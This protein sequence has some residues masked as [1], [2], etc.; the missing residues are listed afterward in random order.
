M[1][2][3]TIDLAPIPPAISSK[4]LSLPELIT[5]LNDEH[6]QVIASASFQSSGW[7]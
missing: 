6:R 5:K 4:A 2:K 7:S 3:P 1:E